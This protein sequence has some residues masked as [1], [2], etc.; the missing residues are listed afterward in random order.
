MASRTE[1]IFKS[2]ERIISEAFSFCFIPRSLIDL[3]AA[4]LGHACVKLLHAATT[5]KKKK[6]KRRQKSTHRIAK[7]PKASMAFGVWCAWSLREKNTISFQS[8]IPHSTTGTQQAVPGEPGMTG[9][10]T[11]ACPMLEI[12]N[13]GTWESLGGCT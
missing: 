5:L 6:S 10:G 11:R 9:L 12:A 7:W 2:N 1:E 8:S 4:V 13:T 3:I